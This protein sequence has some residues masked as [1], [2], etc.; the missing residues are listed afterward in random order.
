MPCRPL[1]LS[2]QLPQLPGHGM[3]DASLAAAEP[4]LLP[5][6]F[7]EPPPR[8]AC[9]PLPP[10]VAHRLADGQWLALALECHPRYSELAWCLEQQA[11]QQQAPRPDQALLPSGPAD[12]QEVRRFAAVR[13]KHAQQISLAAPLL[14]SEPASRDPAT[15]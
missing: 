7:A 13:L 12:Q 3:G 10:D 14:D 6:E 4:C 2:P 15:G 1:L 8:I 11:E 5:E 9:D